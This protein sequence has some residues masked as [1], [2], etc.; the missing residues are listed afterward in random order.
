MCGE[1]KKAQEMSKKLRNEGVMVGA[2]VFPMVATDKA[3]VRAQMSAGL[4]KE[5]ID[6]VLSSFEKCGKKIGLI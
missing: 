6:L 1:S 4:S 3:R 2:I 5:D